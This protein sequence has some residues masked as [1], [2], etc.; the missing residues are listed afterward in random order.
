MSCQTERGLFIDFSVAATLW[1]EDYFRLNFN[2]KLHLYLAF[3]GLVAKIEI[4]K[5]TIIT[6]NDPHH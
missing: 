3:A 2:G 4:M 6:A 1:F 5:F